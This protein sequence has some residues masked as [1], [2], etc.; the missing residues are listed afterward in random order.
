MAKVISHRGLRQEAPE[1]TR[2]ALL[3]AIEIPGVHGVE[4]DIELA[5]EP[6]VLHQETMVPD[7]SFAKL[8]P[9]S[10]NF[11]SRDWVGEHTAAEIVQLDA[12]SWLAPHFAAEAVP[13]LRDVLA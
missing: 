10:R 12:G 4:F 8:Q 7:E 5:D 13:R 6:V 3:A 11:E 1:N 9:A 2:A